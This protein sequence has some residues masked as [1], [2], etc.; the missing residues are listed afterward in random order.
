MVILGT[1][2]FGAKITFGELS[3]KSPFSAEIGGAVVWGGSLEVLMGKQKIEK[4]RGSDKRGE[5]T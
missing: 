3:G 4:G 1:G 2:D 5:I